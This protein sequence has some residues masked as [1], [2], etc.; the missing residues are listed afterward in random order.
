MP[1]REKPAE[2]MVMGTLKKVAAAAAA[3]LLSSAFVRL[4]FSVVVV[5]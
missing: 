3:S 1:H 5:A 4:E 2:A